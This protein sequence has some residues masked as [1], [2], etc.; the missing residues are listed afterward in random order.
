M[1]TRA[2]LVLVAAG[3]LALP[4][5]FMAAPSAGDPEPPA[6]AGA[7][8]D[9]SA[10]DG[11]ADADADA[12]PRL[13]SYRAEPFPEEHSAEP[14]GKEWD[15]A[16]KVALEPASDCEARRLRE[17]IRLHCTVMTGAITLLGGNVDGLTMRLDPPGKDDFTPLPPAGTVV[18]PV[19]RGDRRVIEW[20]EVSFGYK[21]SQ[22]VES[23]LVLEELWLPG[24]E[25]PT[26]LSQ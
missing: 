20:L 17:W 2:R 19:R 1:K 24:D 7:D 16:P 18:F 15:A 4:L 6:D 9:E 14:K 21:G 3:A 5:L 10:L 13:P 12:A 26:I 22:S 11:G 25:Q 23:K 8:A